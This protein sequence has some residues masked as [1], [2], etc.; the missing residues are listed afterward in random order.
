MGRQLGAELGGWRTEDGVQGPGSVATVPAE[1]AD[2]SSS[3][4]STGHGGVSWVCPPQRW[5]PWLSILLIKA[6]QTFRSGMSSTCHP[7]ASGNCLQQLP[8]TLCCKELKGL[9]GIKG[10]E[11]WDRLVMP[12]LGID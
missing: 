8:L 3:A 10:E 9:S 11:C 2:L 6:G 5:D 7:S 12:A 1:A 4:L